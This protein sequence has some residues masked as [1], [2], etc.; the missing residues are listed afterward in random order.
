MIV[1]Y[2]RVS[3]DGHTLDTQHAALREAGAEQI[4]S[5]KISGA[6]TERKALARAIE[7]LGPG[8]V[9]LVTRGHAR[10]V[11]SRFAQCA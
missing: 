8:D 6:V 1:G 4:F 7:A 2:A 11:N 3:T 10:P 5:E 9:L